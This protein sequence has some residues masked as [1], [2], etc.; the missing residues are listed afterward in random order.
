MSFNVNAKVAEPGKMYASGPVDVVIHKFEYTENNFGQPIIKCTFLSQ[1]TFEALSHD[2]EHQ[3]EYGN[4]KSLEVDYSLT[5]QNEWNGGYGALETFY[6]Q[7]ADDYGL[8]QKFSDAIEGKDVSMTPEGA[9]NVAEVMTEVFKGLEVTVVLKGKQWSDD[10]RMN[11]KFAS[12][13]QWLGNHF[14]AKD[15]TAL[16]EAYDRVVK[17]N[18]GKCPL[19]TGMKKPSTTSTSQPVDVN[20]ADF[21]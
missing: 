3:E 12:N 10:G 20:N 19:F 4:R 14:V 21:I 7:V 16:K 5:Y 8:R 15:G 18:G 6:A 1:E 2:E 11:M 9:K 17:A 13:Q